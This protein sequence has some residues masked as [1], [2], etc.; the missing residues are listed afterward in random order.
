MQVRTFVGMTLLVVAASASVSHAFESRV[1]FARRIGTVD[2]PINGNEVYTQVP[3]GGTIRLRLQFGVFDDATSPAPAGGVLGWNVGNMTAMGGFVSPMPVSRTPGR[4]APFNFSQSPRANGFPATDPF[5]FITEI[6]NTLGTQAPPWPAGGDPDNPP[7]PRIFGLNS[8]VSVYEIS[9]R[10]PEFSFKEERYI[11]VFGNA[12]ASSEWRTVGTPIPPTPDE[13]GQIVY[14][15]VPLPPMPFDFQL[16]VFNEAVP[17]P[18]SAS[19]LALLAF[20]RR[21]RPAP[22]PST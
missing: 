8:F 20:S 11:R 6:D 19:L 1:R 5:A 12:L 21:R 15:P 22:C 10:V 18:G 17:S 4:L 3:P 13:N 16:R 7:L 14:A 9:L 2:V